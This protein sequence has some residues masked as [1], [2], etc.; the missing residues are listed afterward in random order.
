MDEDI[1]QYTKI[2][3]FVQR[4]YREDILET[5]EMDY[6]PG[7]VGKVRGRGKEKWGSRNEE[8]GCRSESIFFA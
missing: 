3:S 4:K 6:L 1:R 2:C 5:K 7:V 8:G